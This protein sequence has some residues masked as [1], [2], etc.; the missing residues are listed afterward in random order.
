MP[1]PMSG[2]RKFAHKKKAYMSPAP[3]AAPKMAPKIPRP[4]LNSLTGFTVCRTGATGRNGALGLAAEGNGGGEPGVTASGEAM[5]IRSPPAG[6][7]IATDSAI[8]TG[9]CGGG[10]ENVC[11]KIALAAAVPSRLHTGQFT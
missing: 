6:A 5:L 2:N 8:A 11:A 10:G 7:A 3:N 4:R 9:I 1:V